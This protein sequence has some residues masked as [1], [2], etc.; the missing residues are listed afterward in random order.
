MSYILEALEKSEQERKQR[1]VPDLQTQPTLYPGI[2]RS[3]SRRP[4][5]PS[6]LLRPTIL[7]AI[8]LVLS[9]WLLRD[10]LPVELEIKITRQAPQA[11]SEPQTAP[12]SSTPDATEPKVDN[13]QQEVLAQQQTVETISNESETLTVAASE[14]MEQEEIIGP[15]STVP[16]VPIQKSIADRAKVTLQP[17]PI[18]LTDDNDPESI[19]IAEPVPFLEEL[20]AAQQQELPT[21][22][23][24]GHTYSTVAG[25]RLIIINN[26]IKRE[27]DSIG[28]GLKLEEITW[29]GVILNYRGLRFQVVT[30]GT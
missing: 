1:A 6:R 17:A 20:T 29:D 23:F 14:E 7:L 10:H 12:T 9:A 13:G 30:T 25:D 3:R 19:A 28:P 22:K 2:T 15:S 8:A 27:G 24:A 21:M 16:A 18:M 5:S 4:A 11:T 26:G